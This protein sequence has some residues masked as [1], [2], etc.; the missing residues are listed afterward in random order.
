MLSS[1]GRHFK[2]SLGFK[3]IPQ[4]RVKY[5]YGNGKINDKGL[6]SNKSVKYLDTKI[7]VNLNWR[8]HISV[9]I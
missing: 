4:C 2:F 9:L 1:K 6:Y 7:D 5:L 3:L 8:Q